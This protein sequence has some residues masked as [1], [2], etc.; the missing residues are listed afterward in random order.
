L[1]TSNKK[2]KKKLRRGTVGERGKKK[3]GVQPE[4]THG[5]II[6]KSFSIE[7]EWVWS[8]VSATI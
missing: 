1:H 8:R 3:K 5:K 2:K 6:R 4:A 7:K